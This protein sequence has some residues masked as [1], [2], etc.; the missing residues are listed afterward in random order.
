MKKA[1][2][3][4]VVLTLAFLCIMAGIFIG[5]NL[6]P[7]YITHKNVVS[8]DPSSASTAFMNEDPTVKEQIEAKVNINTADAQ[9]LSLLPGIG[10]VLA[11]RIIDYRTEHGPFS[12]PEDLLFVEGIGDIRLKEILD[13]IT[14]GG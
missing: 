7:N 13:Y 6:M 11:Q 12:K 8:S 3:P 10:E 5:R 9:M 4:M 2:W 1:L 14:V